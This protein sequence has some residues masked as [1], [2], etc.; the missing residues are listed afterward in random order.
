MVLNRLN[1]N[2]SPNS[3]NQSSGQRPDTL[4]H[5]ASIDARVA[6]N[7]LNLLFIDKEKADKDM[8]Y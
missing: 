2:H 1:K 7:S 8:F 6:M 5:K 3:S 4:L